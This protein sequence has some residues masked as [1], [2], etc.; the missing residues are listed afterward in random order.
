MSA[1]QKLSHQ[2]RLSLIPY[3]AGYAPSVSRI[4]HEAIGQI[5]DGLYTPEQKSAWSP[6]PRSAYHWHKRLTRSR[7]WLVVDEAIIEASRPICCGFINVE[8]HFKSRGYIDSLYV[9][10]DYQHLGIAHRLYLALEQWSLGQEY[11]NLTVD[12]SLLSKHLFLTHGFTVQHRSYQ[13]KSG[14]VFMG[15]LMSKTLKGLTTS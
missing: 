8:T 1:N 13:E 10:P 12:A 4:F 3:S 9:R 2:P 5:D 7:A 14:Q 6:K 15:F 11:P